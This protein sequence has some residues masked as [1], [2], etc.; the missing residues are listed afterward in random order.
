MTL[1]IWKEYP[2]DK[3]F[4]IALVTKKYGI[5]SQSTGLDVY[6]D[7]DDF[8]TGPEEFTQEQYEF[9]LDYFEKNYPD[10]YKYFDVD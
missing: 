4:R 9:V 1:D 10:I 5:E 7:L 2:D 3:K 8:D 6:D